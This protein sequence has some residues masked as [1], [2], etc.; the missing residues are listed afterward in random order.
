MDRNPLM[1]GRSYLLKLA[2]S[3]VL[4]SVAPGLRAV[5]LD[6]RTTIAADQLALNDIGHCVL[7]LDRHIAVDPYAQCKE[8]GSFILIDRESCDTVGM[9]LVESPPSF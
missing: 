1:P 5:D 3:T 8:T 9:G 2:T 6:M 4:A 7:L